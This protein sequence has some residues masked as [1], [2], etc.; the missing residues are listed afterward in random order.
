MNIRIR[1]FGNTLFV[2]EVVEFKGSMH[3]GA[4][5]AIPQVYDFNDKS[6]SLVP[7]ETIL[8]SAKFHPTSNTAL[9]RNIGRKSFYDA[10]CHFPK[11]LK[12]NTGQKH[13]IAE[14]VY[15]TMVYLRPTEKFTKDIQ[16]KPY[17]ERSEVFVNTVIKVASGIEKSHGVKLDL[18]SVPKR[19]VGS[20]VYRSD[21]EGYALVGKLLS[22]GYHKAIPC[23]R[24]TREV[25]SLKDAFVFSTPNHLDLKLNEIVRPY[26]TFLRVA[27][28]KPAVTM[29]D[30]IELCPSAR[31]K[32]ACKVTKTK[33][34]DLQDVVEGSRVRLNVSPD[35]VSVER[36][37]E[38]IYDEAH[39]QMGPVRL[40]FPGG[41]KSCASFI[42]QQAVDSKG[43]TVDA[44][45]DFRTFASKG[46][47]PTLAMLQLGFTGQ[48][49][50]AEDC[51]KAFD[52]LQEEQ[53]ILGSEIL[54]AYVGY[55]PCFR[56][57]QSYINLCK[58]ATIS[59]DFVSRIVSD[60]SLMPNKET[61]EKYIELAKIVR[62]IHPLQR[63]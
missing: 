45:I 15:G 42:S 16:S 12:D 2:K 57:S 53:I 50:T 7:P 44:L 41:V 48:D 47:I 28:I 26:V 19:Q 20:F 22:F 54:T 59:F 37:L 27:I 38:T 31:K 51:Y 33:T 32:I 35:S 14:F 3:S 11:L 10:L 36:L 62:Q 34:I 29:A 30:G 4:E 46:A 39:L 58:P 17:S 23:D 49:V 5:I 52:S 8:S 18:W 21:D 61:N 9:T 60:S 6:F 13:R 1:K 55:L 40:V 63:Y 24:L 56:P 43:E 25:G